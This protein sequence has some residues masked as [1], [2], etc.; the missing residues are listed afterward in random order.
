MFRIGFLSSPP[1]ISIDHE[2][3]G[4]VDAA[5][6]PPGSAE[7]FE[8]V[9]AWHAGPRRG[10]RLVAATLPALA[11][12]SAVLLSVSRG[13]DPAPTDAAPVRASGPAPAALVVTAS[14]VPA[15][16]AWRARR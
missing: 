14:P 10:R 12:A 15:P 6:W 7:G 11:V 16:E 9:P 8:L 3:L 5:E 2:P 1:A 13:H 4:G